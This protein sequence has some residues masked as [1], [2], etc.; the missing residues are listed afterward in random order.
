MLA[1]NSLLCLVA[2]RFCSPKRLLKEVNPARGLFIHALALILPVWACKASAVQEPKNAGCIL[3]ADALVQSACAPQP[4]N[5]GRTV[6]IGNAL[7][8]QFHAGYDRR[9][10]AAAKPLR[11]MKI[12]LRPN[13]DRRRDLEQFLAEQQDSKSWNYRRWLTPE[14]FGERFGASQEVTAKVAAWLKTAGMTD[15]QVSKGRLFVNFSG[16]AQAVTAAFHT[17]IHTY[18]VDGKQHYAN[19]SAPSVPEGLSEMVLEV[20]G[21]NDFNPVPQ[22]V[23]SSLLPQ[24]SAGA[25]VNYLAPDDLAT[26]YN[27]KSLYVKGINGSGVTVAVL[28]QTPITLGDYQAY[29]QKFGLP[30]NDFQTVVVP[31]S[32]KGTGSDCDQVEATL[33]VEAVGAVARNSAILYVW[34]DTVIDAAQYVVD[35]KLAQA[36]SLSY[37]GCEYSSAVY[38]QMIAQ[39]ANAE[40]ITWLSAAGNSGAAGCDETMAADATNGLAVTSPASVPEVTAVGGTAF[41]GGSSSQYWSLTNDAQGGSALSYVPETGWSSQSMVFGGGGGVSS[42]FAKAGYQSDFN[43]AVT[44]GRMVPDLSFAAATSPNPYLIVFNG[45]NLLVGGTSAATPVF[46]GITA[47]VNHD[48][49]AQGSIGSPGLGNINPRLYLLAEKIPSVF[50]DVTVGSNEVPCTVGAPDCTTGTLG[51]PAAIGYDLA[52]GLGSVDAY[53]LASNWENVALAQS[54]LTLSA[55]AAQTQAE[56]SVTFSAKVVGDGGDV[57]N[58]P[59]EFYYS[60]P[61][62]QLAATSFGSAITDSTGTAT[63]NSAVFPSGSNSVSAVYGGSTTVAAGAQSNSVAITVSGFPT[64]TTVALN[65]GSYHAGEKAVFSVTVLAPSGVAL[66]GP[67]STDP[68]YGRGSVTLYSLDGTLQAQAP[69]AAD[70]SATLMSSALAAGDTSF[71]VSFSGTYYAAQSQSPVICVTASPVGVATITTLNASSTDITLGDSVTLT[72]QVSG[73]SGAASPAGSVTFY[74]GSAVLASSPLNAAGSATVSFIPSYGTASLTAVYGGSDTY[75]SST[76]APVQLTVVT[77]NSGDF[78][79]SGPASATIVAGASSSVSLSITPS[80]GFSGTILLTCT[81]LSAGNTCTLPNAVTPLGVTPVSVTIA[82]APATTS[83]GLP[84][85]VLVIILT[86]SAL[87]RKRLAALALLGAG[88]ICMAGCGGGIIRGSSSSNPASATVSQTYT[89]KVTATSGSISH[90]FDIC[91]TVNP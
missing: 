60:N 77:A 49:L 63:L 50:H 25:G 19:V 2:Q 81:G 32:G 47:L 39:Q 72:A 4:A 75:N 55:S 24:Y 69:V 68:H 52:T 62:S 79:I 89:A 11:G 90:E 56:Q 26:I 82:A 31:N 85:G 71:Y 37:A 88:L 42:V 14:E 80:G 15:V 46:A 87:R 10:V 43:T 78:T 23:P 73:P 34:G 12:V 58:S 6:T 59:V 84:L 5:L 9:P 70:G 57:S 76:S 8:A 27:M 64:T 61:Q 40:G 45:N 21:L 36:M 33:D 51:Y 41:A 3:T 83:A 18:S 67:D 54:S 29:R 48:L 65:G 53:A 28:G 30:P 7:Q 35:N 44:S 38:Y 74:S 22:T 1:I 13:A 86:G 20:I 91:I 16:T 17:A 66:G